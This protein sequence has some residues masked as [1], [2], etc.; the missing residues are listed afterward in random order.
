MLRVGFYDPNPSEQTTPKTSPS[1]MQRIL[2]EINEP[3]PSTGAAPPDEE[4]FLD[5]T[6]ETYKSLAEDMGL[7]IGF[8]ISRKGEGWKPLNREDI[9]T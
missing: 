6:D 3:G 8:E 4:I 5:V 9:R 1:N 2:R 7:K